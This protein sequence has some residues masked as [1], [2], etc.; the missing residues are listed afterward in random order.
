MN[1]MGRPSLPGFMAG[2]TRIFLHVRPGASR[3][4]VRYE[5][6]RGGF[7]VHVRPRAEGGEANRAL[8][9]AVS[10]WLGVPPA[11]VRL[12][13]GARGREKL[14]EIDGRTAAEVDRL[15]HLA[16]SAPGRPANAT[17]KG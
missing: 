1:L 11:S 15:L 5:P 12:L 14:M 9:R 3:E 6:L 13:R 17:S 7:V 2:G 8:L 10:G 4:A 16:S